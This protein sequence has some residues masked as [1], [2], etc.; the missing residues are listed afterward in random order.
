MLK[1]FISYYK[2]YKKMLL[3]DM[4]AALFISVIG[5][6]YPIVTNKMLNDF[7]PNAKYKII[8]I[9]GAVV[10][11]LYV[12]R[13]LLRYFVMY[14]G[15]TIGVKMQSDLLRNRRIYRCR[16]EQHQ[17]RYRLRARRYPEQ[18]RN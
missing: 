8:V 14:Y 15:H 5:M 12:I 9:A 10:L 16:D 13:M 4:L 7:I 11:L 18:N 17:K 3:L 2:P 6:V 1:R